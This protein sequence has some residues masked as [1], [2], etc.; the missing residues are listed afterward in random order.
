[1]LA[2]SLGW[3]DDYSEMAW[4]IGLRVDFAWLCG[5]DGRSN[6]LSGGLA[7]GIQRFVS[8]Y[9]GKGDK[10]GIKGT[11]LGALKISLPLSIIFAIILFF[12]ADW[13]SIR[14]SHQSELTPVLRIFSIAIPFSVLAS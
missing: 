9:K 1:M 2:P 14:V 7:W 11:I 6:T 10:S 3:L 4:H 13:V 8:F 5:N 12:H